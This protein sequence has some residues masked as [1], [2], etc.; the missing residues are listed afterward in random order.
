MIVALKTTGK[1]EFFPLVLVYHH[2]LRTTG[3][4]AVI[5]DLGRVIVPFDFDRGYTRL[6]ALCSLGVKEI[7]DRIGRTGLV[8][9]F[10][11]GLVEPQEFV[12][13]IGVALGIS[14]SVEEFS[15]IWN[16]IF[17]PETL[18]PEQMLIALKRRY[19]LL[20]LSN[21]N[22]LHF[23]GLEAE[24]PLL[25]HFHEHV[26]SFRVKMMKPDAGIYR[27]AA[28]AA[29]CAPDACLFIDDLPEN[30]DG[31]RQAGMQALLFRS[32]EELERDFDRLGI[33]YA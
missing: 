7:R 17:L 15:V 8:Q 28:E 4:K 27:H 19:R 10:E 2:E 13:G 29:G 21:T 20:L 14:L 6:S 5:F 23:A 16:S 9:Q 1:S 31:A 26:L 33:V 32:R 25:R 22:M 11:T 12:A 3:I 18:I 30:V 24:Y